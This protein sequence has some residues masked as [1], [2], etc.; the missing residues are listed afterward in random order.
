MV[1]VK[2]IKVTSIKYFNIFLW[3]RRVMV[4]FDLTIGRSIFIAAWRQISCCRP[5]KNRFAFCYSIDRQQQHR[6]LVDLLLFID[7]VYYFASYGPL[8]R[9]VATQ[10][11]PKV[12]EPSSFSFL[13]H[14]L[15]SSWSIYKTCD[16]RV[17]IILISA[18]T[19]TSFEPPSHQLQWNINSTIFNV[20]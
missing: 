20:L 3:Y 2:A 7:I 4:L 11:L 5:Y 1:K 19:S 15:V 13:T 16:R 14:P 12:Q 6:D 9:L 18:L 10:K 8:N 17:V